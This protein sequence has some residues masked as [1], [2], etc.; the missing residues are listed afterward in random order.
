MIKITTLGFLILFGASFYCKEPRN[1]QTSSKAN[2]FYF[3]TTIE[4]FKMISKKNDSMS[5][6]TYL[7]FSEK[8]TVLSK[9]VFDLDAK[10]FKT[11]SGF[12]VVDSG[13]IKAYL[14]RYAFRRAGDSL[15][16]WYLE[17]DTI[18]FV[19]LNADSLWQKHL[20]YPPQ[21][22]DPSIDS[23]VK[24]V[25]TNR[26]RTEYY[27]SRQRPDETY[28]DSMIFKYSA[29]LR[30]IPLTLSKELDIVNGKK[31]YSVEMVYNKHFDAPTQLQIPRRTIQFQINQLGEEKDPFIKRLLGLN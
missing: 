5:D 24:V 20:N 17:R 19:R 6:T 29:D 3:T 18:H 23:L 22:V 10:I 30:D 16:D 9:T 15:A 14:K 2:R 12:T 13:K 31:L 11:D 4:Y 27:Y 8:G 25:E 28:P 21:L 7:T 26:E 1:L